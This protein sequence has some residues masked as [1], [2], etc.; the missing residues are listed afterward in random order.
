MA[1]PRQKRKQRSGTYKPVRT[2]KQRNLNIMPSVKG[3][4]GAAA[5][6]AAWDKKKSVN[7]NYAA[8]GLATGGKPVSGKGAAPWP[9][10]LAS[11]RPVEMA[12]ESNSSGEPV[13]SSST[14]KDIPK[15]YARI[16]RDEQ[17]NVVRIEEAEDQD[18]STVGDGLPA[19]A[20]QRL[21]LFDDEDE[22]P[23]KTDGAPKT[24][25]VRA[26][27][28]RASK[29]KQASVPQSENEIKWLMSL[30]QAHG[31]DI[32]AMHMDVKRNVWQRTPGEL[33]RA[34]KK[35]GGTERLEGLIRLQNTR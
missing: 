10:A 12:A 27:E 30:V 33:R 15:G 20:T 25:V 6:R 5:V 4:A 26:L 1:N 22:N 11:T 24:D 19:W 34:I 8:I 7:H 13:A 17:G 18:S 31:D 3:I 16:I 21:D 14:S 23:Q 2:T 35:A 9:H 32:D 29:W 28:E